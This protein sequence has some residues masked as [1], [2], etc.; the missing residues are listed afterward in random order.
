[1]KDPSIEDVKQPQSNP[2]QRELA[3]G[4]STEPHPYEDVLA[5]FAENT[6]LE[7][8]RGRVAEHLSTCRQCRDVLSLATAAA[9]EAAVP[10]RP[11]VL[12][13]RPPLRSWLPWVGAATVLLV[14]SSAGLLHE[15][16]VHLGESS[17]NPPPKTAQVEATPPLRGDRP[18]VVRESNA[19]TPVSAA[20]APTLAAGATA[21]P[22]GGTSIRAHWRINEAGQAER[23]LGSAMWQ[24]VIPDERAMIRVI[25]VFGSNV[26]LGGESPHLYHS[27]D[28]GTTWHLIQL[29]KKG[30]GPHAVTHIR[31]QG[32]QVGTVE[33]DDGTQWSTVDGGQTWK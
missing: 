19:Q 6:L 16:N 25:S 5:A 26:W 7:R 3:R 2:L 20:N 15:R 8:E 21:G 12:P 24:P 1:V 17:T 22:E 32:E 18:E 30:T 4:K 14:V 13:V 10:G 11:H 33:A 23:S 28:D 31:F 9:P 29:P 27:K